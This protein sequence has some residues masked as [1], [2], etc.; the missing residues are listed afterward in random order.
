MCPPKM[1]ATC[2][3]S[4]FT[5]RFPIIPW[6]SSQVLSCSARSTKASIVMQYDGTITTSPRS[7]SREPPR[8]IRATLANTTQ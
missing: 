4:P 7:S 1:A 5:R 6:P 3:S 2:A 8:I